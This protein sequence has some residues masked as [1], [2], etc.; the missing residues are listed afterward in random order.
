[1]QFF[2][3]SIFHSIFFWNFFRKISLAKIPLSTLSRRPQHYSQSFRN[4]GKLQLKH[5]CNKSLFAKC[6][7][8]QGSLYFCNFFRSN[9]ARKKFIKSSRTLHNYEYI[10]PLLLCQTNIIK[11]IVISCSGI[12]VRFF[13]NFKFRNL[14]FCQFYHTVVANNNICYTNIFKNVSCYILDLD[15]Y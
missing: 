12:V 11:L 10:N 6:Y 2:H 15:F 1:M 5:I 13:L 8:W 3:F 14:L 9:D 4:I 7:T